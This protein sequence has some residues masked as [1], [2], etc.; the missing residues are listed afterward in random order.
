MAA[1]STFDPCETVMQD[2][3]VQVTVDDLFYIGPEKAILFG[4]ALIIDLFKRLKM[5][6]NAL[7]ILRILWFAGQIDRGCVGQFPSP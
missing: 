6:S 5:I 4:K 7:I 3:A 1:F 2:A